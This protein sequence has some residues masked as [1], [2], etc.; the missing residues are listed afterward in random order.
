MV[1]SYS[2]DGA[3]ESGRKSGRKENE[4]DFTSPVLPHKEKKW[5]KGSVTVHSECELMTHSIRDRG[6]SL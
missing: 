1:T 3:R 2:D 4:R 6:F 5:S